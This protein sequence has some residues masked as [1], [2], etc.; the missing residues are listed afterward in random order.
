MTKYPKLQ[1]ILGAVFSI[2]TGLSDSAQAAMFE[3]SLLNSTWQ[4]SFQ[5]ELLSAATDPQTSWVSLL[6]NDS[7]EVADVHSEQDAREIAM[8]LLWK[9]TFPNDPIPESM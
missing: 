4:D 2:D 1:D 3:R 5:A 7:Y 9:S 6:S 8:S